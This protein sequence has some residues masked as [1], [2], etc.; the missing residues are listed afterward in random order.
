MKIV[1]LSDTHGLHERMTAKIPMG[2]VL[3]HAGDATNVGTPDEVDQFLRWFGAQ[4]HPHK[5]LV[6]GNHDRLFEDSPDIAELLLLMHHG[7][8]TYLQDSGVE[9]GGLKFWGSPWQPAFMHWSFNLPRKGAA[10]R[11]AWNKIPLDTDVLITHCPPHGVLDEVRPRP[12][13]WGEPDS[14]SGPLGCEELAIRMASLKPRLHVFGHIHDGYGREERGGV[15][16]VN[17]SI[18]VESY[19]PTNK[20]IVVTLSGR[21]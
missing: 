1:C 4:P 21:R 14:G 19:R 13:G 16:C 18:C 15:T 11:R 7:D 9:I 17:A 5:I 20:P 12:T 2:D 3:I 8:I 6:A 10:L